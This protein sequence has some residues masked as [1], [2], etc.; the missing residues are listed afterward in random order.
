MPE[1][2]GNGPEGQ[3]QELGVDGRPA[4]EEKSVRETSQGGRGGSIREPYILPGGKKW[5]GDEKKRQTDRLRAV[6]EAESKDGLPFRGGAAGPKWAEAVRGIGEQV[7]TAKRAEAALLTLGVKNPEAAK[8]VQGHRWQRVRANVYLAAEK[9]EAGDLL[10]NLPGWLVEAI[11]QDYAGQ[12]ERELIKSDMRAWAKSGV[13]VRVPE[14]DLSMRI[15]RADMDHWHEAMEL[16]KALREDAEWAELLAKCE[17]G[18]PDDTG[19]KQSALFMAL[20]VEGIDWDIVP[21]A[22][23]VA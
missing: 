1:A 22:A 14:L 19:G 4:A 6:M 9:I 8:L 7:N 20:D 18:L 12:R 23:E 11:R 17:V 10:E 13:L 2:A 16:Y 5:L 3:A 21:A 15:E